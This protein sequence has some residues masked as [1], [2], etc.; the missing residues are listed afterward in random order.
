MPRAPGTG[1]VAGSRL[2]T[3][4]YPVRS[5]VLTLVVFPRQGALRD[6]QRIW[7]LGTRI[8]DMVLGQHQCRWSVV[9]WR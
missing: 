6:L 3:T 8:L 1:M 7:C 9:S 5:S 2:S 4:H